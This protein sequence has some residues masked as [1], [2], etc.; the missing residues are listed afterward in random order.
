MQFLEIPC[1][2]DRLTDIVSEHVLRQKF[3]FKSLA[4]SSGIIE[5]KL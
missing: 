1:A 5:Q 3:N 4:V 2:S